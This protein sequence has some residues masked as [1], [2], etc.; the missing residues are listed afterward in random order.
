MY[1]PIIPSTIRTTPPI[2][3]ITA[4]KLGQP[5][6]V[7]P[8]LN[9]PNKIH[10]IKEKDRIDIKMP[11]PIANL[12]GRSEKERIISKARFTRFFKVYEGFPEKRS[13]CDASIYVL[14]K[15]NHL[16]VLP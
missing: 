10:K 9:T 1:V 6:C 5:T 3:K 13:P 14:L 2:N 7:K 16:I 12:S 11:I 8:Q 4:I 15:P